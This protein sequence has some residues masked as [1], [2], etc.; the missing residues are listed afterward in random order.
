MNQNT[1]KKILVV[2]DEEGV[3]QFVSMALQQ[4]GHV[5]KAVHDAYE[6]LEILRDHEFDLLISD[7]VMPGMDGIALALKVNKDHPDM[8]VLMMTGYEEERQRAYGLD[9]LIHG[10]VSKPFTLDDLRER[11]SAALAV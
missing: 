4:M 2:E 5:V 8:R 9:D 10:V 1:I 3:R 11:V 6:A 7:I